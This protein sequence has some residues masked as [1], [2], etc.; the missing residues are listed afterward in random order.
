MEIT[1][2]RNIVTT[3]KDA[4]NVYIEIS[5][6]QSKELYDEYGESP[7]VEDIVEFCEQNG[8][9][10][11]NGN[12]ISSAQSGESEGDEWEFDTDNF[13]IEWTGVEMDGNSKD[14]LD[15]KSSPT[16]YSDLRESINK[17]KK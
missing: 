17:L 3:A 16:A 10:D 12:D 9:N 1:L 2:K 14:E 8:I 5:E 4:Q 11:I 13:D 15:E 7:T 6:E